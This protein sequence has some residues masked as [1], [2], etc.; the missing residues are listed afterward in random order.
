MQNTDKTFFAKDGTM[1]I[2]GC[3]GKHGEVVAATI[4]SRQKPIISISGDMHMLADFDG[5]MVMNTQEELT[6]MLGIYYHGDIY[7]LS[8]KLV[9][10]AISH[11]VHLGVGKGRSTRKNLYKLKLVVKPDSDVVSISDGEVDLFVL[12]MGN[13]LI[14]RELEASLLGKD[15]AYLKKQGRV[16][17]EV[18]S[19]PNAKPIVYSKKVRLVSKHEHFEPLAKMA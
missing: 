9:C 2:Y 15:K 11:L 1:S 17:I 7:P 3:V 4:Y 18:L 5:L 14:H 13:V 19:R 10:D 16:I 8:R 6:Q 12:R